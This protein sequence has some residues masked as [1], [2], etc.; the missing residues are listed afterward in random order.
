[1]LKEFDPKHPGS[2]FVAFL[3]KERDGTARLDY[4]LYS[5]VSANN[6]RSDVQFHLPAGRHEY[7]PNP[8]DTARAIIDA[9]TEGPGIQTV[10]VF[11]VGSTP[12]TS[13]SEYRVID[14]KVQPLRHAHSSPW[15]LL[16]FFACLWLIPRLM[17]PIDRGIARVLR[18]HPEGPR[19]EE[20]PATK[21]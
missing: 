11:V 10:R 16:G 3:A 8:A 4:E 13:M 1:M 2:F 18:I 14:N 17:K 7:P 9:E 21:S 19:A 12:W 15:I 6:E 5:A 20:A